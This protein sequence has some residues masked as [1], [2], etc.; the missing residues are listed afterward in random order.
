MKRSFISSMLL[1]S[2][3]APAVAKEISPEEALRRAAGDSPAMMAKGT[4]K[5]TP[6]LVHTAKTEM[7]APAVY[8]F[9]SADEKGFVALSAD[10]AAIPL[11]GYSDNGMFSESNMPPQ[12]EWWLSEYA[13]QIEYARK[14]KLPQ[15][16]SSKRKISRS[17]ERKAIRP[18]MRTMWDQIQPYNAQCPLDGTDRTWTGCVATAMAQVMKYWNYPEKGTGSI[19]YSIESLEKKVSMNFGLKEFDWDNMKDIYIEGQ[20]TQEE[21]D[22]VA[23]LMKACGYSVKMQYSMDASGALGLNIGNAFTKYFEYDP[24]LLYTLRQYYSLGE[25]DEMMYENL[26]NVGPIMYGGGSTLGGGHSFVCDGYDGEGMYHFN[27]GW[28]G[29]SDG[30][31][32]LDALSPDA[33]GTGGGSGGGYNFSQD[34]IFGIQPPTG[35][36]TETRQPFLTQEGEL[37]G[38]LSGNNL[39]F[40]LV[41]AGDAMW[42]NYNAKNLKVKFGAM[43]YPQGDNAPAPVYYDIS[44]KRISLDPG[45]GTSP[46]VMDAKINLKNLN[47]PDGTYKVVCGS[48]DVPPGTTSSPTDGEGFIEVKPRYGLPNYFILKVENGKYSVTN[49]LLPPLKIKGQIVG[50]LCYGMLVTVRVTVENPSE[51]ERSSGFAPVFLDD[52]GPLLLGESVCL[53]IP[54]KSTVT[55]E[56]STT[57]TQFVQYMDAYLD[58]PVTFTFFN[59]VNF[60][61]Y[62]DSFSRKV[63]LKSN[64]GTPKV[65]ITK[66]LG[67]EGGYKDRR[68]IIIPNAYDFTVT[69]E[70]KLEEGYFNYPVIVCLCIPAN[71]QQVEIV[72]TASLNVFMSL[73]DEKS[74]VADL[75]IPMSYPVADRYQQY[76]L[77]LTYQGPGGLT[78]L[79]GMTAVKFADVSTIAETGIDLPFSIAFDRRSSEV[80]I[81]S[82]NGGCSAAAYTMAGQQAAMADSSSDSNPL[83]L[84][85]PGKGIYLISVRDGEGNTETFKVII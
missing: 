41:N 44:D 29:M 63:M 71:D 31:F 4:G 53:N 6:R 81:T 28:S 14:N 68:N 85:L 48:V 27:W 9:N 37:Q 7:G 69:G 32:A 25:W 38:T 72:N 16:T 51:V 67:V 40:A 8:I 46:Q 50:D 19:T 76:Y 65:N 34:A 13:S 3:A 20:Y 49:E 59:E 21:A 82:A 33:L 15:Y 1:L 66:D 36:P 17:G 57:L 74:A 79:T 45:Y 30:Y 77:T 73:E 84:K 35:Q 62:L 18:L 11:L 5:A 47:L 60:D 78:P 26:K 58:E 83:T 43:F 80:T 10:D 12:L 70:M 22:A 61:F 56:W 52:E 42:V 64:P 39:S 55:H 2:L 24:N 54:P 75:R 23:Y